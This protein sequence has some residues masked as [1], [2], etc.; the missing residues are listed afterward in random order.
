MDVVDANIGT[1]VNRMKQAGIYSSTLLII[2]AKH[3]QAPIDPTKLRKIDPQTLIN[4]TSVSI[5]YLTTD[6]IGLVW[7]T[8]PTIENINQAKSDL[9]AA[10]D[11]AGISNVYAGPE[12]WQHG[13]GNPLL[14]SRVPDLI[15]VVNE[16]VIYTSPTAAKVME[17]GEINPDDVSTAIFVHNPAIVAKTIGER[18]YSRQIAVTALEALGAPVAQ[19]DGA[20]A[21][22][23][24]VLPGLN[25]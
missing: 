24:V 21:D 4:A 20:Q 12:V 19:L 2:C 1:L 18:V 7:L 13:F 14:D 22:G 10:K 3:G 6:D 11:I 16:G 25:F 17:H 5:D 23:T 9:L 15:I 8:T